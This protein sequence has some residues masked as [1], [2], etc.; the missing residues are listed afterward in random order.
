MVP[1]DLNLFF[2]ELIVSFPFP[3]FPVNLKALACSEKSELSPKVTLVLAFILNHLLEVYLPFIW[4]SVF[5]L[6]LGLDRVNVAVLFVRDELKKIFA[7]A[8]FVAND[9]P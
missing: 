5:A 7:R 2:A 3:A 6:E 9:F 4:C 1:D 8:P